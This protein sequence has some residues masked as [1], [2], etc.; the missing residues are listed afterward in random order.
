MANA[1]NLKN[2]AD[3]APEEARA[4]QSKA[5]KKS[6]EVRRKK[7]DT[8]ALYREILAMPIKTTAK[9]RKKLEKIGYNAE[10]QGEPCVE[11]VIGMVI[12]SQAM[13]GDIASA[14]Y[15]ND[16]AQNPDIRLQ[17]ERDR[18]K[19]L[20]KRAKVDVTVNAEEPGALEAFRARMAEELEKSARETE[21]DAP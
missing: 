17:I 12:A 14:R 4:I 3:R 9:M 6:G 8:K 19:A 2:I 21:G 5:G 18:V 20:K 15:L 7:R 11:E 16:Y 10:T 13:Q 1:K